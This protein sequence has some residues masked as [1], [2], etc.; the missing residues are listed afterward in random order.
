MMHDGVP[1]ETQR[2]MSAAGPRPRGRPP[3]MTPAALLERIRTLA[4]REDGLFRIHRTHG[5]IYARARRLFGSW[6]AAVAAA[7][8][9]YGGAL[10]SARRRSIENRRRRRRRARNARRTVALLAPPR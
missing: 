7:G 3:E 6:A 2:E 1:G 4:V 9:D 10:A 8:Q 5:A